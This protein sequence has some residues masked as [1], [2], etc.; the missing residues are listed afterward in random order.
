MRIALLTLAT[1]ALAA[2]ALAQDIGA[3]AITN[4]SPVPSADQDAPTFEKADRNG[5]GKIDRREAASSKTLVK[6]FAGLDRDRDGRL[7]KGEFAR[8]ETEQMRRPDGPDQEPQ[9]DPAR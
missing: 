3:P 5:D 9:R 1:L 6:E 7:D 2:P 8:L 4:A